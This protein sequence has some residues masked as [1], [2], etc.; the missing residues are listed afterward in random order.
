MQRCLQCDALRW[1]PGP[2]CPHCWCER[3]EWAPL[4]GRGRLQS[5]VVYRRQ[6]DEAFPVPFAVGLVELEE[7]P[8]IEGALVGTAPE[9]LRWRMAVQLAWQ[10]REHFVLPCFAPAGEERV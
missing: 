8:R 10:E 7:G 5:W 2:V 9:E 4:S 1:P 3:A 6:Y